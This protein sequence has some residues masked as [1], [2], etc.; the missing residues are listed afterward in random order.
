LSGI[1]VRSIGVPT[2]CDE[3]RMFKCENNATCVNTWNIHW[4]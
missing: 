1:H 2:F 4:T 3:T